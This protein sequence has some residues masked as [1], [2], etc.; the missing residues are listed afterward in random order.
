[1][2][3]ETVK[4]RQGAWT[5]WA[6]ILCVE[7]E[8]AVLKDSSR[9]QSYATRFKAVTAMERT[10]EVARP[11]GNLLAS[12][13]E[14]RCTCWVRDDVALLQQ[15]G[16]KSSDLDWEGPFGWALQQTGGMCSAL[17]FTTEGREIVVTAMDS[18]F[19]I[20]E[21]ACVDG[22]ASEWNESIRRWKSESLYED[23]ELKD[24]RALEAMVDECAR[25]VIEFI[26]Q[27]IA[28]A[29]AQVENGDAK[30]G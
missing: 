3:N 14:C 4:A 9:G 29:P 13:D 27:P 1:M 6:R 15:V 28:P 11:D 18:E 23:D 21:Y 24:T 26:R 10:A 30:N 2:S 22:E 5:P 17:V 20:G 8:Y 25:K 7:C 19:F 16:F 12:C